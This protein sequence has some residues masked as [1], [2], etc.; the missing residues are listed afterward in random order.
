MNRL[1]TVALLGVLLVGATTETHSQ[2][3]ARKPYLQLGAPNRATVCWRASSATALTVRFGTDSLNLTRVSAPSA[4]TT[5]AC[6]QL[7]TLLPSTKYF[8]K[9]YNGSTEI[10]GTGYQY[11]RTHPPVGSKAKHSFWV[12]GDFGIGPNHATFGNAQL[13]VR[14]AFIRVNGGNHTDGL[15]MMGDVAYENG[16]D[17]EMTN[18]VFNIYPDIMSNSFT[19]PTI[20]NHESGNIT[21]GYLT[22]FNLPTTAQSGGV[23]SGTEN[24]YSYDYGNIHFI[25]LDS[26]ISNRTPT[27]AMYQWLQQDLQSSSASQADWMVVYFHHS[28]YTCCDHNADTENK[29]PQM[30][31]TFMNL[32]EQYGVDISLSGH[33][34]NYERSWLLDSARGYDS[35]SLNQTLHRNWYTANRARIVLDSSTG[36]PDGTGPYRKIKAGRKGTV[37]AVVG[38]SGKMESSTGQHPMIGIKLLMYGSMILEVQDS[39]LTARFIDSGG[40]LRDKFQIIKKLTPVSVKEDVQ[41]KALLRNAA[42]SFE[43]SGRQFRFA[44]DNTETLRVFGLDGQMIYEG[45]PRGGWEA[46]RKAF[47][48]GEYFFRHGASLGKISLQ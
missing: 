38:S 2:T 14:D 11:L 4:A 9:V 44:A 41:G 24:Y 28:P 48:A 8:Y 19:W 29:H 46:T 3:F 25:I 37:Y 5:N 45:I 23:A 1:M 30:R 34:H 20:G 43:Q 42:V 26:E 32:L 6:V 12:I 7:D 22:A 33:S 13:Q 10:P 17:A 31:H 16:T 18:G 36:N 40:V 27:G 39:V 47:P 21:A 35:V 15:L